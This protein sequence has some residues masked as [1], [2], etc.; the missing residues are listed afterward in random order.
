MRQTFCIRLQEVRSASH[1]TNRE[2]DVMICDRVEI[3][4]VV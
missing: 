2:V 1:V 3:T 4:S